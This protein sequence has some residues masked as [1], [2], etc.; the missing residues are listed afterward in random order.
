MAR[1]AVQEMQAEFQKFFFFVIDENPEMKF[2]EAW[3][4]S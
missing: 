2:N 4:S 3:K 1:S